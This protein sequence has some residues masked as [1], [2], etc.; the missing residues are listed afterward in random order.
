[1]N[2]SN[3]NPQK[4]TLDDIA[5][6]K[7]EVLTE[8]HNKKDMMSDLAHLIFAPAPPAT[9]RAGGLM[10]SLNTGIAIFDGALLGLKM[11]RKVRSFFH[12]KR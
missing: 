4:F 7:H 12:K 9:T 1:M 6:R 8:I 2:N 10:H 5:R 3:H 11:M